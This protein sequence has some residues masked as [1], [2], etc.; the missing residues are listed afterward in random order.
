M[1]VNEMARIIGSTLHAL[2]KYT[3]NARF[4]KAGLMCMDAIPWDNV[5]FNQ[6]FFSWM[7]VSFI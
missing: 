1:D 2:N 7:V 4:Q 5:V 3:L 6:K